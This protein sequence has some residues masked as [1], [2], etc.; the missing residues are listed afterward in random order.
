MWKEW[1][2]VLLALFVVVFGIS[3]VVSFW[4]VTAGLVMLVLSFWAAL[5][6]STGEHRT[7][8]HAH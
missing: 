6:Q 7:T 1:I 8:V 3:T 4:I 2:N 5:E